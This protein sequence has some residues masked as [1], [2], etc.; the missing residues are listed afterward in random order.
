M[1]CL[2]STS[3]VLTDAW[4]GPQQLIPGEAVLEVQEVCTLA[5]TGCVQLSTEDIGDRVLTGTV[6]P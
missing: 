4:V 5:D 3:Y 6:F 1:S 2:V